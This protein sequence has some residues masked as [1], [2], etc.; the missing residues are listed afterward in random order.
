MSAYITPHLSLSSLGRKKEKTLTSKTLSTLGD[1]PGLGLLNL[2]PPSILPSLLLQRPDLLPGLADLQ[3][4][5]VESPIGVH[6]GRLGAHDPLTSR[7][8]TRVDV[9]VA[10]EAGEQTA[11]T[12][13][14]S[15]G[16]GS[17][18]SGAVAELVLPAAVVAAKGGIARGGVTAGR[19]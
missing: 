16:G 14:G 6:F 18:G 5:R 4:S 17:G 3:T 2:G 10:P 11:T 19:R 12:S 9:L 1:L 13:T 15:S 8:D 7:Q